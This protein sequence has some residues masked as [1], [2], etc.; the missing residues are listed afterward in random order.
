MRDYFADILAPKN[1]KAKPNY[2]KA[3]QFAFV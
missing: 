2:G 1:F 3:A